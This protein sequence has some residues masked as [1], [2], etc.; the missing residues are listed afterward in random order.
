M[1][2]EP[3]LRRERAVHDYDR[4]EHEPDNHDRDEPLGCKLAQDAVVGQVIGL[5]GFGLHQLRI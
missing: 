4:E 1:D 5:G 2:F 3:S